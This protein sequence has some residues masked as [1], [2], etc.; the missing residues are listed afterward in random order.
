MDAQGIH[1]QCSPVGAGGRDPP[2]LSPPPFFTHL[3]GDASGMLPGLG[4]AGTQGCRSQPRGAAAVLT[5]EHLLAIETAAP[6]AR[7]HRENLPTNRAAGLHL[8]LTG[9]FFS[10]K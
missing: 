10:S 4:R 7:K 9:L 3:L 8:S 2:T 6:P 5:P 1:P